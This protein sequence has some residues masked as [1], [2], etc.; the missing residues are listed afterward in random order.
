MKNQSRLSGILMLIFGI[1]LLIWPGSTLL[2]FCQLIG[3]CLII[4]G[5]VEIISSITGN[6]DVTNAAG[7]AVALIVGIVFIARPYSVMS[8]LP[9]LIGLIIT[10]AGVVLLIKVIV[11]REQGMG[12][13]LS[14]IGGVI[15]VVVGILFMFNPFSTIKLLM[16]VLGIILIYFGILRIGTSM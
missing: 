14:I 16:I 7:G 13:I 12:A 11:R 3:W 8:I 9:F 1:I 10:I 2:A 15:A 6:T 4:V 5:A